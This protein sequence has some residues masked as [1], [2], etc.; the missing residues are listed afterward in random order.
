[1]IYFFFFHDF[2]FSGI[3]IIDEEIDLKQIAA[4][5]QNEEDLLDT[6]E[7]APFIAG[8]VDERSEELRTKQDFVESKKWKQLGSNQDSPAVESKS[9]VGSSSS[10]KLIRGKP[11]LTNKHLRSRQ[12]SDSDASPRR[13]HDSDSDQSPPR[14]RHDS[15][16][17]PSPPRKRHDS[18]SDQSPPRKRHD[19]DADQSPPR[20]RHDS[21]SD[22][23]PPRKKYDSDASPPR[24]HQKS[25]SDASPPRRRKNLSP[26]RIKPDPDGP[27]KRKTTLDG[28]KAGLQTGTAL[29]QEMEE[30]Q[31]RQR[32]EFSKMDASVTGQNAAT[33]IRASKKR[34]IEAKIEEEREKQEKLAKLQAAYSKWNK[35][36][37]QGQDQSEKLAQDLYEM[38][39]PMAR[40][41]GDEDLDEYQRMQVELFYD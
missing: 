7:D 15:D 17:D 2:L 10:Q 18:D 24:K 9:T 4:G 27:S 3:K 32:E 33:A 1:M 20:K 23:S 26:I 8:V 14:K 36:L 28:K 22:Q 31:K 11:K 39:K 12:D 34:Q 25:D 29:R 37:K 35:G 40:F 21:D 5:F 38:S 30:L 41:A 13:R 6:Q 19:S 16:S